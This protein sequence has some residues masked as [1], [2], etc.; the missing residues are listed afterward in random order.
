MN[1]SQAV[2]IGAGEGLSAAVAREIGRDHELTL[3][4]RSGKKMQAVSAETAARTILLDATDEPAVAR[5]F[6]ELPASPRV[7]FYNASAGVRGPITKL[8][9]RNLPCFVDLLLTR[10]P[11]NNLPHK[12]SFAGPC[13]S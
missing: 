10:S 11:R 6:D 2:I 8:E 12:T 9:H 7:V 5:L 3:V 4:A 1:K 13:Y